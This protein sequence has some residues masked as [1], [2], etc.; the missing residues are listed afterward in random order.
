MN[1]DGKNDIFIDDIIKN[2]IELKKEYINN[3]IN[4]KDRIP[5]VEY[6]KEENVMDIYSKYHF[7]D[8]IFINVT[9]KDEEDKFDIRFVNNNDYNEIDNEINN[10]IDNEID[11][12]I[13]NEIDNE[14]DKVGDNDINNA[15]DKVKINNFL[16]L[17]EKRNVIIL[18]SGCSGCGKSTLSC[19]LAMFLN[20]RHIISTD[21]IREILRK[22][23]IK[24]DRY[25]RFSTYE[26]WKLHANEDEMNIIQ[27]YNNKLNKSEHINDNNNDK[28]EI[29]KILTKKCIENYLIQCDVLYPYIDEII[30]ENIKKNQSLIIEGVHLSTHVM[31]KLIKKYPNKIIYFLVYIN[32]KET[33]IKRF[34]KRTNNNKLSNNKNEKVNK[35]IQNFNY[36]SG[37][38]SYLLQ[39]SK[40]IDNTINYI[41]NIDI[42]RSLQIIMNSVYAHK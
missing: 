17:N 37:I 2:D 40:D 9:K 1:K 31:K 5:L 39:S 42:Y 34:A 38:Q 21:I 29:E 11:N 15:V 13:N 36:I 32:D 23:Q 24:K 41:E 33:S 18:L 26:S 10:E 19:L 30:Y 7:I 16:H 14:I 27:L 25:L 28:E 6:K 4:Y 22:F 12:E 3:V 35:Y 8:N 20:I